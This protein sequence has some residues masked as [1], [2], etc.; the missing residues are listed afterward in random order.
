MLFRILIIFLAA[1]T[2]CGCV[3]KPVM[4]E[5]RPV[6]LDWESVRD[7]VL[8]KF[9]GSEG[10]A[11]RR[12]V[13]QRFGEVLYFNVLE[14]TGHPV[15]DEV[16]YE[17]VE[18]AKSLSLSQEVGGDLVVVGRASGVVEDVRGT[19]QAE[20]KEGTGYFKKEKSL[21]GE[22]VNVE[23]TRTVIR[24]VPYVIRRASLDTDY[25]VFDLRTGELVTKG[26]V[27]EA[28]NKKFGGAKPDGDLEYQPNEAPTSAASLDELSM[29]AARTLAA[30]ISRMKVTGT[31]QLDKGD[32][33]L[34]RRGVVMAKRGKWEDAVKYW[35]EAIDKEPTDAA[36][37]YNLG[38]AHETLGDLENLEAARGLY[39]K[40]ITLGD[41][42]LYT[43]GMTRVDRIVDRRKDN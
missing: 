4:R 26:T 31:I 40:A 38:V 10:D 13:Y 19:D 21:D 32:N 18:H 24:T 2:F 33:R 1:M 39:E 20:V 22:W 7:V 43:E 8:L 41:N 12:H 23:I 37:Y 35:N 28:Q 6:K 34:A 5:T 30:K 29:R 16:T 27:S 11:V 14:M 17:T 25:M 9:D 3:P 15:F 42:P 36:A